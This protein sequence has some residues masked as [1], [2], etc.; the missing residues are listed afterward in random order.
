MKRTALALSTA[1]VCASASLAIQQ[2][3]AQ[4]AGAPP[5]LDQ[6]DAFV[7]DG[8]CGGNTIAMG[9][10]PAHATTARYHG[11]KT[12]DGHWAVIHYDEDQ[13][14]AN[15]KPFHIQQYFGYDADKKRFVAVAFD[16]SGASYSAGTSSG[17]K[18]GTFTLDNTATMDGKTISFRDVFTKSGSSMSSHTGLTKDKNGNWVKTDQETCKS[19]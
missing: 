12:L 2:A 3:S 6:L 17:W 18:D 7:G 16:N 11:E 13:T 10:T 9:K 4:T 15:P 1:L 14:A 8:I 19:S 5:P